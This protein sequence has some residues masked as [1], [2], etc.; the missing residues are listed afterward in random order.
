MSLIQL[1]Q[2]RK[3]ILPY[4]SSFSKKSVYNCKINSN[5]NSPSKQKKFN[6]ETIDISDRFIPISISPNYKCDDDKKEISP[7]LNRKNKLNKN[8][9]KKY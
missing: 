1:T 2:K 9:F 3:S 8:L 6:L 4:S 7:S 5:Y